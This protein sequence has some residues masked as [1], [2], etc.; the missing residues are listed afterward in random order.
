MINKIY[1]KGYEKSG[2]IKTTD[3]FVSLES[4]YV[5]ISDIAISMVSV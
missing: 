3:R 2:N 5:T 4:A 1:V